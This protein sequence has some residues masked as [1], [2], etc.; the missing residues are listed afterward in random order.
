MRYGRC[1]YL[2]LEKTSE[3]GG[4]LRSL[5][6]S[7]LRFM[8]ECLVC[9]YVCVPRL[10]PGVCGAQKWPWNLLGLELQTVLRHKAAN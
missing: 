5:S 4:G 2:K 9:M 8:Y 10:P 6:F 1:G 3:Q 7:H